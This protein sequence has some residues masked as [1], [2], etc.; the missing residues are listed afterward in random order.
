MK[1]LI[2]YP[3][4]PQIHWTLTTGYYSLEETGCSEFG[5]QGRLKFVKTQPRN[6][7]ADIVLA[8]CGEKMKIH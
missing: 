2:Y 1:I 7:L 3:G 6:L 5:S 4:Y 8:G